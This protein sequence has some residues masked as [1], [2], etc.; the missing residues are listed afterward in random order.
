MEERKKAKYIKVLR[1]YAW[2]MPICTSNKFIIP[3]S[4]NRST[5]K[6]ISNSGNKFQDK[7]TVETFILPAF[8]GFA[9]VHYLNAYIVLID[10][11]R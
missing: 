10:D 2:R 5:G 9:N 1:N 4:K 6:Y 7:Q 11:L 8:S 3:N